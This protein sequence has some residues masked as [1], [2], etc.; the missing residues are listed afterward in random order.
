MR[1]LLLLLGDTYGYSL[2][3][4]YSASYGYTYRHGNAKLHTELRIHIGHRNDRA[5]N[6]RHRK[7]LR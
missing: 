7:P 3:Y 2:A 4:T 5:G 1:H 6:H